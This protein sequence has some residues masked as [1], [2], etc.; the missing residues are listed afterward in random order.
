MGVTLTIGLSEEDYRT[1]QIEAATQGRSLNE[2]VGK[3]LTLRAA[4]L[5]RLRVLA[6][7]QA[8]VAEEIRRDGPIPR[9]RALREY[10][11]ATAG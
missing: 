5:R 6:K 11:E 4:Y 3:E 1:L 7:V 2:L 10:D 9:G 8:R